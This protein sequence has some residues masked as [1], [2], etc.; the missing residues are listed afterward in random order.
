MSQEVI[1]LIPLNPIDTWITNV[2]YSHSGSKRTDELYRKVMTE[3]CVFHKISPQ[4]IINE[5][6][7]SDERNFKRVNTQRIQHY[8]VSLTAKESTVKTIRVKVGVIRSFYKYTDLPLGFIPQARE[9]ITFH[10]RDIQA[11]EISQIIALTQPR[12][13][14][15]YAMIAQSGLRPITITK[16][17]LKHIEDPYTDKP[18]HMITVPEE[19][20]KGKFGSHVTFI[21]EEATKYLRNY[22]M[23]RTGLNQESILFCAYDKPNKP[24]NEKNVSRAFQHIARRLRAKGQLDYKTEKKGKPSELRLYTLRKFFK[25]QTKGIGDEDTNY[26]MGHTVVGSNGNYR[27]QNPEYYRERYEKLALPFL[28][29]E[30]PTPTE[31]TE[32]IATLKAQHQNE[33]EAIKNEYQTKTAKETADL[34]KQVEALQSQMQDIIKQ[35][36]K[37]ITQSINY[38]LKAELNKKEE[39]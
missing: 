11:K 24:V 16:L 15:I 29:L 28:R 35:M 4:Q 8:I 30:G 32:I 3:F 18:S 19:L 14:A 5:Y 39:H 38:N 36:S 26:L 9:R 7:N 13:K 25:R 17:R 37:G 1:Q 21:G 20:T 31:T 12:E 23:T 2:S 34:R 22:L 33:L 6:E 10:N 27:P